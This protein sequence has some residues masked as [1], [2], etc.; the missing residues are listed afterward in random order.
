MKNTG[1]EFME[2]TKYYNLSQSDQQKGV[3]EPPLEL[4]YDKTLP[5]LDLPDPRTFNT[6]KYNIR[7]LTEDRKSIRNYST[8][9]FSLEELTFL[10]WTTQGVKEKVRNYVTKRNVPSAGS[11]HSFESFLL[12]NNVEGIEPGLYRYLALEHK[13]LELDTGKDIADKVCRAS[14]D[15]KFVKT[16]A[17]T[18]I[19]VAIPYRTAWR[20]SERSYRYL[21]L[22]AGHVCQNLYLSAESINSGVCAIAAFADDEMNELLGLDGKEAFVIYMATAGKKK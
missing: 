13:L 14:L 4:A 12:I 21:H 20:Y 5:Q 18:F 17:A 19:W 2:K 7:K 1:A 16:A 15:Q 11:R 10:L 8:E 6:D 3:A 9:P 22:D